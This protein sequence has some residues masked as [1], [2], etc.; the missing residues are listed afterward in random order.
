MSQDAEVHQGE[1]RSLQV[2]VYSDEN[3]TTVRDLTSF[4]VLGYRIGELDD[5]ITR[6]ELTE[7][8]NPNGSAVSFGTPR[9]DGLVIITIAAA[10]LAALPARDWD[11]QLILTDGGSN[12]GVVVEGTLTVKKSLKAA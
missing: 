3:E 9:S 5:D 4:T 6:L 12:D 8:A 7:S 10:D 11:H 2:T 1:D